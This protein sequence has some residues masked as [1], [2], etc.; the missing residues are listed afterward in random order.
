MAELDEGKSP[1]TEA[2][3][4]PYVDFVSKLP[5]DLRDAYLGQQFQE[6]AKATSAAHA[7][8]TSAFLKVHGV[9]NSNVHGA[10]EAIKETIRNSVR[11]WTGISTGALFLTGLGGLIFLWSWADGKF[12]EIGADIKQIWQYLAGG[13]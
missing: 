4:D 6:F 7:A 8:S 2:V 12:G 10:E 11:F 1:E 3:V 13:G 9:T 5:K